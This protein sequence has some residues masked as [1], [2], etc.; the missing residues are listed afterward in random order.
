MASYITEKKSKCGLLIHKA[1]FLYN[2]QQLCG[3]LLYISAGKVGN[4]NLKEN[5]RMRMKASKGIMLTLCLMSLLTIVFDVTTVLA[6][7]GDIM[8]AVYGSTPTLDG[9]IEDGEWDDASTVIVSVTGGTNCTVYVKQNGI[10]LYVGFNIPDTTYNGSDS[11]VVIFDVD[12]DGNQSL[13]TDDMWLAVS[14]NGAKEEFNVTAG[15]WYPT[16]VS[17]W[18]AN[19]SS[20]AGVWQSEYSITYSKL[21][22][23]AGLNKTLGVMFLIVDKDVAMGWYVW[24]STASISKPSTW[25]DM[26]PN[27]YNWVP[28]FS[29]W[30]PLLFLLIVLTVVIAIYKRRLLEISLH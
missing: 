3:E 6:R 9:S 19:V 28:E 13:Q 12:H 30:T 26:T 4:L 20:T 1:Y 21:D 8:V 10:N 15:G 14:R 22:V 23:T 16:T 29:T 2:L 25:S 24:P 17:A 7:S 27:G 11:C 5:D 18:S